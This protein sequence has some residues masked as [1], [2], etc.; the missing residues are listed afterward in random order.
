M[1]ERIALALGKEGDP[2]ELCLIGSAAC[3]LGGMA[4]RTSMD[5]DVWQPA[6]DYER[7]ELKAAVEQAGLLFN[8]ISEL[9]PDCSYIQ[10]VEPGIVQVG[11][12]QSVLIEKIGRM[13]I[14]RPPIEN[15]IAAKLPR[16]SEKDLEDIAYLKKKYDVPTD[17]VKAI[18]D[19]FH[20]HAAESAR[21]N[22]IYLEVLQ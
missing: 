18:I 11:N 16:C 14:T 1:L 12:F 6:S 13:R 8:P 4:G 7:I 17:R 15:I 10:I 22:L 9:E 2:V 5:L 3:I 21:E 19:E 20:G